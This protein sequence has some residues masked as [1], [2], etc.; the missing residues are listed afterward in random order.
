[1]I[2][3]RKNVP[4]WRPFVTLN[5][6]ESADGKLAPIDGGKINFGSAEDREQMELFA[7]M[8]TPC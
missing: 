3:S 2:E 6:A 1:M 8:P 5:I 7:P 4:S